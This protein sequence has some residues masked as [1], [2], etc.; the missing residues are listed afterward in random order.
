MQ[1]EARMHKKCV[2]E[3]NQRLRE[4]IRRREIEQRERREREARERE[5]RMMQEFQ[6]RLLAEQER[7]K[8][9]DAAV[10]FHLYQNSQNMTCFF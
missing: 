10:C 7:R 6:S 5:E 3:R 1:E 8:E 9:S 2:A 4:E